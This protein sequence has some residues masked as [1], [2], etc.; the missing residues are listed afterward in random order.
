M[1]GNIKVIS[2]SFAVFYKDCMQKRKSKIKI[3]ETF[4]KAV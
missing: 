4:S 1:E 2:A 3:N